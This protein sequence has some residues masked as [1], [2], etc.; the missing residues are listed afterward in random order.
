MSSNGSFVNMPVLDVPLTYWPR[1][2][3]VDNNCIFDQTGASGNFVMYGYRSVDRPYLR[4]ANTDPY[5]RKLLS[6]ASIFR[7]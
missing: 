5:R 1:H 4:H 6:A 2:G 7:N 3:D